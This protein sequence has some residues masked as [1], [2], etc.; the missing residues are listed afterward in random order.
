MRAAGRRRYEYYENKLQDETFEDRVDSALV[1]Q[2]RYPPPERRIIRIL[3]IVGII[4]VLGIIVINRNARPAINSE[5]LKR[6]LP[7][8]GFIFS[9][10][11]EYPRQALKHPDLP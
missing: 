3:A 8:P 1:K 9:R 11:R 4:R 2:A 10:L 7:V 6:Q 5:S